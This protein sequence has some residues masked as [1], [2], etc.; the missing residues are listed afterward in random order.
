MTRRRTPAETV[1]D[2]KLEVS[3]L[4]PQVRSIQAPDLRMTPAGTVRG[5]E[6]WWFWK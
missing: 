2:G 4:T 3:Y 1:S 5:V 6:R